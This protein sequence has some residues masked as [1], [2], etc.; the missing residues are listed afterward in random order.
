VIITAP[1]SFHRTEIAVIGS[2]PG[3]SV[4]AE[5]LA[6]AGR[7]VLLIE[8]GADLPQSSCRSFSYTEMQQ[9]YRSGGVTAAFGKPGVAYAEGSVVG[10]GSEVN[11]GLYHRAPDEVLERWARDSK[12]DFLTPDSLQPHF[13]ACEQVMQP[14][15]YPGSVPRASE[16]LRTGAKS[17]GMSSQDVPRLVDLADEQDEQDV[18]LSSR[19]SMS[20]T[21]IPL[22]LKNGGDLLA[23][24]RV[25]RISRRRQGWEIHALY[26]GVK[27]IV[28]R[29]DKVFICAGATHTPALLQRS[30]IRKNIGR[31]LSLQPMVKLTAEFAEP[32]NYSGMGIAGEQVKEFS[33]EYSFG[34][35]ISSQA[36]LAINLADQQGGTQLA[37]NNQRQMISYYVMSRGSL[38]GSVH[39]LPV[40][41]D[42]LVRYNLSR[43]ELGN[44]G[45]GVKGL[46]RVLLAAGATRVFTGLAETPVVNSLADTDLLPR[47]F[48]ADARNVM[49]VHLMSSCPMGEDQ[50]RAAVNS[51]GRVHGHAGLYVSDVST[52]CD[53]PGVNPQGTIMALARRNAEH[54]LKV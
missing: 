53:S 36:H 2:G 12:V 25:Q 52:F 35:A 24:T 30:G 32:V 37:V 33:P 47:E 3:G 10:G 54:F 38:D 26:K 8:E 49:T 51:W 11:S 4:T 28:I 29:A 22:F 5:M 31:T 16:I 27:P 39:S 1:E 13:A 9:K 42:P 19:R 20:E 40:F 34:C 17:R 43:Q 18:E 46:A 48:P 7:E 23:E 6:S 15:T 21:Y 14:K 44:L 50:K 45:N 41:K